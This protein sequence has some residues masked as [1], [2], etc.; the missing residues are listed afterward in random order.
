MCKLCDNQ[1]FVR[2]GFPVTICMRAL[3][4]GRVMDLR[5]RR[6]LSHTFTLFGINAMKH[7]LLGLMLASTLPV[8]AD[9]STALLT[10]CAGKNYEACAI[11]GSHYQWGTGGLPQDRKLSLE[12]YEMA[13]EGRSGTGCFGIALIHD[14]GSNPDRDP[15]KALEAY[16]KAC[17]FGNGYGCGAYEHLTGQ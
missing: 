17:D 14:D 5:Y 3:R 16:R 10:E 12:Y 11:V 6:R 13:C 4:A 7:L 15:A 2:V 1:D 9:D 8:S